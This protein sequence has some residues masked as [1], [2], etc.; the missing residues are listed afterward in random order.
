MGGRGGNR[1]GNFAGGNM[2]A[3]NGMMG[4]RGGPNQRF[5][6]NNKFGGGAG[7]M[8][9]GGMGGQWGPA[10]WQQ[11]QPA[12]QRPAGWGSPWSQGSGAP[13]AQGP[14]NVWNQNMRPQQGNQ[15]I[16]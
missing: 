6:G 15:V 7:G 8:N 9:Q 13:P 14:A 2:G 11:Q 12:L 5:G 3:G 10:P 16:T 4:G 1:G